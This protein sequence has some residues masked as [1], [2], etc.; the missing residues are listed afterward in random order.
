MI[1]DWTSYRYKLHQRRIF[2]SL[3]LG[4]VGVAASIATIY[5]API[6]GVSHLSC[7]LE[8]LSCTKALTSV[9]AKVA[10]IPL[11]VFGVF[12][13]SFWTLNLRAFE[14]TSNDGYRW[15]LSWITVGG[16]VVSLMLGGI[17]F[18]VLKAP[19][20]FCL[21]THLCNLGSFV[22]LSPVHQWRMKTPFTTEQ[23]RHFLAISAMAL[24][25]SAC[26]HLASE[27]RTLRAQAEAAKR[28]IW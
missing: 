15:F 13:F 23:F 10:G 12:Y 8:A 17:M 26:L 6:E 1:A 22:A 11:G 20:G 25:A 9:Y 21:I 19:C 18:L 4:L 7:G 16:A 2:L 5:A 14:M 28:T 3:L 27:V 24:L